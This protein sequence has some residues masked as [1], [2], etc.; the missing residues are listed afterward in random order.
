MQVQEFKVLTGVYQAEYGRSAG[1]QISM[2][3][4][5]GTSD[6]H[7]SGYW[8]VRNEA[9]N[10]DNWVNSRQGVARSLYRFNDPGY[11]IGGPI[12][13]PKVFNTEKNKLFFFWA[14]EF[15]RQ[16]QPN[17]VKFVT[18]PTALERQGDFSQTVD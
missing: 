6:F 1:A 11:T 14:E 8:Y 7:V 16:V 13:I 18:V 2:V 17:A 5:S 4:K 10:A 9:F 15:Q 3:T 12:F